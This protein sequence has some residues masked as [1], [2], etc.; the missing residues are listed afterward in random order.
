MSI[1]VDASVATKWAADEELS[2]RAR[3][4]YLAEECMAPALIMAEVGNAMWKKQRRKIVTAQQTQEAMRAL[5]GHLRLADLESLAPRAA[6]IAGELDHPIY[7]CCY[8][9]LAERERAPLI[10][11]DTRLLAAAK[12]AKRIEVRAL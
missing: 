11:A 4:V 1:V 12:Q 2:D 9:A 5:P 10:S 8:L 3:A 6:A 7:D